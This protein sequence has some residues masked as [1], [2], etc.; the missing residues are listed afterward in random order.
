M[1]IQIRVVQKNTLLDSYHCCWHSFTVG[2]VTYRNP[3]DP[4][5]GGDG[6]GGRAQPGVHQVQQA[7]EHGAQAVPGE[8][9]VRPAA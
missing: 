9:T 5:E 3:G 6:R 4:A 1:Q 2:D 7:P 8:N